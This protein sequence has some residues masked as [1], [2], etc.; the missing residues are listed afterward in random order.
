MKTKLI[1]FFSIA[2]L[3]VITAGFQTKQNESAKKITENYLVEKNELF[4][5][6]TELNSLVSV[7]GKSTK[8][9]VEAIK[10]KLRECR[11][12]YKKI[13]WVLSYYYPHVANLFNGPDIMEEEDPGEF[14]PAHGLQVIE[15][16]LLSGDKPDS[17]ALHKLTN[18][19]T[20]L[21]RS[22]ASLSEAV[23]R[24]SGSP[25]GEILAAIKYELIKI[26]V[27][28][29]TEYD[30]PVQKNYLNE[31]ITALTSVKEN[32]KMFDEQVSLPLRKKSDSLFQQAIEYIQRNN[33]NVKFN[34]LAF[35]TTYYQPLSVLIDDYA[36]ELKTVYNSYNQYIDIS[37]KSV[38][39]LPSFSGFLNNKNDPLLSARI[40]LGKKLFFDPLLSG[41]LQRSC[42]SCHNPEKG[43]TDG[44]AKSISFDDPGKTLL[45]NAPGLINVC[46]QTTFFHDSRERTLEAQISSVIKNPAELNGNYPHIISLLNQSNTYQYMFAKAFPADN[47][48]TQGHIAQSIADY[49][50]SLSGFNSNFDQYVAGN[51]KK[52]TASEIN[53]F[54]LF[55]GKARCGSCHFVPLFSGLLP[56]LYNS[57]EFEVIG[58]LE[59]SNFNKPVLDADK[60]I[61]ALTGR[62][63][64]MYGF[65]VPGLRNAALTAP[66]MHNGSLKTL[67]EVLL[68]YNKGGAAGLGVPISNQ[69]LPSGSL[70]LTKREMKDI[71][72]FIQSL[73]DTS[74]TQPAPVPL[75]SAAD[76]RTL[77]S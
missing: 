71:I 48:V 39:D 56:P 70:N 10:L 21:P 16:I 77:H 26:T 20:W 13:E 28:G 32:L 17:A 5:R 7:G 44:L 8:R 37:E 69:T 18:E 24:I 72:H 42:A 38:F 53:G 31:S 75:S 51:T 52:L 40:D 65:K 46:M 30:N 63:H 12:A 59:N 22:V 66:Y 6:T 64:Q 76:K 45:R 67:E 19:L 9:S 11:L 1:V 74:N 34:R 23:T 54:N 61:G 36:A 55:M 4:N 49:E 47:P 58:I 33:D 41:N 60:G 3:L 25:N 68:F 62:Q 57:S 14:E 73:T 29:F 27:L 43:F 50:R 35:I 2:A 15:N